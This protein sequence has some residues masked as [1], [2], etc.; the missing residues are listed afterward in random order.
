MGLLLYK[1]FQNSRLKVRQRG[2]VL[3]AI[4][5]SIAMVAV[6]G[7]A[8]MSVVKGPVTSMQNVTLINVVKNDFI[9]IGALI[10]DY[11][12]QGLMASDCD[13][14][15]TIEP[16]PF[17][18]AATL[19]APAGGGHLPDMIGA[20]KTDP[21]KTP[22]GYCVWDHGSAIKAPGCGGATGNRLAG[23]DTKTDTVFAI[24]S[25][26]QDGVFQTSC[27]NWTNEGGTVVNKPSGSDD[28]ISMV[29]YAS[30]LLPRMA[31]AK[32]GPLPDDACTANTIGALRMELGM[33]QVCMDTG[34][35]EVGT[36]AQ[37]DSDFVPVTNA[38][39]DSLNTSNAIS[40]SGFMNKKTV[41]VTG[42]AILL[43][44]GNP[45]GTTATIKAGDTIALRANAPNFPETTAIFSI[46]VSG[47]KK[48][49]SIRTRDYSQ[50]SLTITP[51]GSNNMNVTVPGSPGY[52]NP[53][54]FVIK[55][56]GERI[57][58]PLSATL[59]NTANFQYYAGAGYQGNGC[60]NKTLSQD[61]T[62]VIDIRPY[63]NGET[64]YVGQLNVTDSTTSASA[65]LSGASTGWR[66]TSPWGGTVNHNSSVTAYKTSSVA[67]NATC[68]SEARSCNL[69]V[70]SG[71]FTFQSCTP[72]TPLSCTTPWG[73]T[74]AHNAKVT[75][76]ATA[77]VA[78]GG[79][80]SAQ[81]RVCT[82][83]TLSG[84]NTAQ[85]CSVAA[86][87]YSYGA[88]SGYGSCSLTCGGGT[89]TRTRACLRQDGVSSSCSLCGNVCSESISC[90]TQSCCTVQGPF[91][92][93]TYG[94]SCS[95]C[96]DG[97]NCCTWTWNSARVGYTGSTAAIIAGGWK[98]SIGTQRVN[99]YDYSGD[100]AQWNYG[101]EITRTS[102]Y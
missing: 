85:T 97:D 101:Y 98:Y 5:A 57:T 59:T 37:S 11:S 70:L 66:C 34:W 45:A 32:L 102:C 80:C 68:Q 15:G 21:W 75:A 65:S 61:Q 52:G 41:T 86:P 87:T 72:Q 16:L 6:L 43:I 10:S 81:D 76:Y 88:W 99:D 26:G 27:S 100:K 7:A 12:N 19:P 90:N 71:S 46:S 82:N 93:S 30:F 50:A 54:G 79:S 18:T 17:K 2:N 22:Y 64:S 60:Q 83:G 20:A 63:A 40:F 74:V 13:N 78:F 84:T 3:F 55:N 62:C 58:L 69:G 91:W 29:S 73:A 96:G 42:S 35:A 39:L 23:G 56:I 77:N 53:V 25:A 44:N 89:Q 33:V 36:S 31:N 8:T 67:Y 49:W 28:Q 48:T 94:V 95:R 51:A 38:A 14:D 47:I 9:A 4:Y 24:I 92:Q 1:Q